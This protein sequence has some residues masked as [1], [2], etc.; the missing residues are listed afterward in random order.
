MKFD[1]NIVQVLKNFSG[2]NS[3][4][5]FKPGKSLSTISNGK[6][7]LAKATIDQEIEQE[8]AIY[9]LSRF[10]STLSLF[11][12]PEI[13]IKEKHMTIK[14]G[15]RKIDYGFAD[16]SFIVKPPEK[17][18]NLPDPEISFTITAG[19]LQEIY[20]ALSILSLPEISIC[21]DGST[22]SVKAV[23]SKTPGSDSYSMTVGDTDLEF[24]LIIRSENLKVLPLDYT[25]EA[26]SKGF[27]KWT[28]DN[29]LYFITVE[30]N[31][32]FGG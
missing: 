14:K 17:E 32:S 23:D 11:E 13:E 4:I 25:V 1:N 16:P 9:D 5:V 28:S 19:Q 29:V 12:D 24:N 20:K 21:G 7:I 18:L 3:S 30:A 10:L 8:F 26:S 6:S 2:I 27:S 22:I 15:K 31:S